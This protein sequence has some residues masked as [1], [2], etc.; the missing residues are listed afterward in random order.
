MAVHFK[1]ANLKVTMP[2]LEILTDA[3]PIKTLQDIQ[4]NR[5]ILI[6]Q[7]GLISLNSHL[8]GKKTTSGFCRMSKSN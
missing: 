2:P 7:F 4:N 6:T 5:D 1:Y 8:V 3:I